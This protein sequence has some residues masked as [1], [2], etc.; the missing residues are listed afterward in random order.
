MV[1]IKSWAFW[2]KAFDSVSRIWFF[3][4]SFVV[5]FAAKGKHHWS[6]LSVP[7]LLELWGHVTEFSMRLWTFPSHWHV[8]SEINPGLLLAVFLPALLFESSFSME[9]HQIK[10]W[11]W[12]YVRH[13]EI[14]LQLWCLCV[15]KQMKAPVEFFTSQ[16][17]IQF[18]VVIYFP[19]IAITF[20]WPF[21]CLD[22]HNLFEVDMHLNLEPR[23][24]TYVVIKVHHRRMIFLV[25]L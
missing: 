16:C 7:W 15:C 10:V 4:L 23:W 2:E 13:K 21:C 24:N 8:G 3:I 5:V 19:T 14:C 17:G 1:R 9:I 18:P 11:T 22:L 12:T 20:G 6:A 25:H